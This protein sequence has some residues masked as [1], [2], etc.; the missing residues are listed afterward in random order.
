METV[1]PTY[2]II[3]CGENNW[4]GHPHPQTIEKLEKIQSE[5][6]RTDKMGS[7][8]IQIAPDTGYTI[9]TAAERIPWYE[10][11]KKSM[12]TK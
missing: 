12:E 7:I 9:Q 5:I 3:S 11:I 10:R 4:Y 1:A 6:L 2:S 8:E